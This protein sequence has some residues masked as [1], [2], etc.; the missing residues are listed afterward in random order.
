ML[1]G[2]SLPEEQTSMTE[3]S[4]PV[5][6]AGKMRLDTEGRECEYREPALGGC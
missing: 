1:I 4:V 6:A 2:Q 5:G 3:W